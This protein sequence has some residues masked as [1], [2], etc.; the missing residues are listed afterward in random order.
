MN[1][2]HGPGPCGGPWTLVYV[3]YTSSLGYLCY[4]ERHL[5]AR[6]SYSKICGSKPR[7]NEPRYNEIPAINE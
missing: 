2:V 4:N 5:K 3:L 6:Q 7:C 1:L